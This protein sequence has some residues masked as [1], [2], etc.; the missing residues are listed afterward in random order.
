MQLSRR[1]FCGK[2][3]LV[4]V[5]TAGISAF[6]SGCGV[7]DIATFAPIGALAFGAI[8]GLLGDPGTSVLV[9]AIKAAFADIPADIAAY[10]ASMSATAFQ[11]IDEVLTLLL[12]NF[13]QFLGTISSANPLTVAIASFASIIL[14]AVAGF[15]GKYFPTMSGVRSA[16]QHNALVGQ[17]VPVKYTPQEMNAYQFKQKWNS[18]AEFWNVPQA[19][20]HIGFFEHFTRK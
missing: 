5:G 4:L 2:G 14:S 6:T 11:K 8:L 3:T 9:L 7:E 19:K 18:C 13:Q 16:L 15:I 12:S 10:R 20:L 1:A 17:V